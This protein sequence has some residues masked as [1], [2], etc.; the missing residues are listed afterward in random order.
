MNEPKPRDLLDSIIKHRNMELYDAATGIY[1]LRKY[2]NQLA[3]YRLKLTDNFLDRFKA[4]AS[5]NSVS[6]GSSVG[7]SYGGYGGYGGGNAVS[8]NPS[9]ITVEGGGKA[10]D[11]L[12]TLTDVI[13][14][15]DA[16]NKIWYYEEKQAILLLGTK[17]AKE[18]LVKYLEIANERNPNIQ[19]NVRIFATSADPTLNMGVD[20]SKMMSGGFTFALT[21]DGRTTGGTGGT[22]GIG[23]LVSGLS[24]D[25]IKNA[26]AHPMSTII[27]QN[28]LA[29]TLNFFVKDSSAETISSPSAITANG[30]EVAFAA[31][32]QIPYVAGSSVAGYNGGAGGVGYDNTAFV[33]VGTTINILPRIQ[34]GKRIKLGTAISV[35]QLDGWVEISS[36]TQGS[37]IR[38]APQTSGRAFAGEFTISSGDTV[39]IAGM[40]SSTQTKNQSKVPFFG[41]IPLLGKAFHNRS[42]QKSTVYLTLFITVT[43]LDEHNEPAIPPG[44]LTQDDFKASKDS[45]ITAGRNVMIFTKSKEFGDSAI[46]NARREILEKK[47]QKANQTI[48]QRARIE[49]E[50]SAVKSDLE[51]NQAEIESLNKR[52][53][54]IEKQAKS[55]KTELAGEGSI[56]R[57]R[58]EVATQ[59]KRAR[60]ENQQLTQ[61]FN[62]AASMLQEA[63]TTEK[64]ALKEKNKAEQELENALKEESSKRAAQVQAPR[65]SA[66]NGISA[67]VKTETPGPP[68]TPPTPASPA[69]TPAPVAAMPAA[70]PASKPALPD[71]D[72][73]F[74]QL[75]K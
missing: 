38:K 23:G 58:E 57:V 44:V 2:T 41:D 66:T 67:T 5:G 74:K 63:H 21:P 40:R 73:L 71:N 34:D 31:T 9:S 10:S 62:T 59:L 68:F 14:E 46:V 72:D 42:D 16:E 12:Q 32:Q 11:I 56:E 30:R 29:A 54:E 65:P 39:V 33:T 60:Q 25:Q 52:T 43:M 27:M 4:S 8:A 3:Y 45:D 24:L 7:S 51:A 1:S 6:S 37:G 53:I 36:G 28:N 19:I 75:E 26:V 17:T 35:S 49:S 55:G 15:K 50:L 22:N 20:W 64:Q 47:V 69:P 13:K 48:E 70:Q 18:K 61:Q